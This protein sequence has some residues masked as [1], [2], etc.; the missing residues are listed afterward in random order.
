MADSSSSA[1]SQGVRSS[2]LSATIWTTPDSDCS[3]PVTRTN[4][5]PMMTGRKRSKF[6]AQMMM[7]ATALSSSRVR[8]MAL[9][10][11]GRCRTSTSPAT[12]TRLPFR[13]DARPAFGV[14]P[15]RSS[16]SR[17]KDS[18]CAFSDSPSV[19]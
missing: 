12:V 5:E 11:P 18:G 2:I 15:A 1:E 10:L 17:R 9:P 13:T 16:R 8:K 6:R 14:M 4:F 7:L 19:W 3:L